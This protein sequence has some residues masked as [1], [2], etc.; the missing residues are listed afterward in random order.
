[1]MLKK[2]GS[3]FMINTTRNKKLL[4]W[5]LC[6]VALALY[7]QS[8][9]QA[10]AQRQNVSGDKPWQ[11]LV[12]T[13]GKFRVLVPDAASEMSVPGTSQRV[14]AGQLYLVKSSTAV[15]AVICGDVMDDP[16]LMKAALE[17]ASAFLQA[18]GKL[19]LV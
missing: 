14:G 15:Y 7:C 19:R 1:M 5:A 10:N 4:N 13:E 16:D 6:L 9:G 8:P 2:L 3:H 17:S 11:E 12:S 18:S